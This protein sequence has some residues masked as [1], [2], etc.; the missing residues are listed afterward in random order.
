MPAPRPIRDRFFE[1]FERGTG[2][3]EWTASVD[4]WGYGHLGDGRRLKLAHRLSW[5]IHRGAI[6]NG[7]KVLHHCDNRRCVNPD[8]LFLGTVAD[9]NGDMYAKGRGVNPRG[10][11]HGRCVLS[12]ADVA[13]IREAV[14]RGVHHRALAAALGCSKTQVGRIA[15]REQRE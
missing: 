11:Q 7:L 3:W 2:C 15:R 5:E 14:T 12:D 13:T 1:K 4:S 6:P 10:T 8:H 9:N